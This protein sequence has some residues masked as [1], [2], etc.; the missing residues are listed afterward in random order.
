MK[1][2]YSRHK[3]IKDFS[4]QFNIHESGWM[5]NDD[6]SVSFFGSKQ[7][8]IDHMGPLFEPKDI[9]NKIVAE[10]GPGL[11]RLIN[12]ISKFHPAK[13]YA[14]EPSNA[15][16]L[17]KKNTKNIKNIFYINQRGEDF[18]LNEKCDTIFSLGVIHHIMDPLDVVRNIKDNLKHNGKFYCW[19][20]GKENNFL[21]LSFLKI[22]KSFTTIINDKFLEFICY[23][24]SII[25]IPYILL[26]KI[27]PFHLPMKNYFNLTFSKMSFKDRI[28][29][30][31]DQLNPEYA[32]YYTKKELI[33]LLEKAGFK[34]IKIDHKQNYSWSIVGT[35]K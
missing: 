10:V 3:T 4:G 26:C 23:V 33:D 6:E 34:E 21:Y 30:I 13:I 17:L 15:F 31:F 1:K 11:G 2:I 32:K 16:S 20:Y 27:Y 8:F 22:F 35:K 24:L 19:V 12:S 29:L 7:F 5:P 18:K 25:L 28:F 14:V 9:E